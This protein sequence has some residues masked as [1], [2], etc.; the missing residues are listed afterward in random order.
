MISDRLKRT[1]LAALKLPEM[2]IRDETLASEVPGWDSIAHVSV[3]AAVEKEFG[4]RFGGLEVM[5]LKNIG[6]LQKLVSK[7]TR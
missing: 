5:R 1:I 4:I 3:L 2:E 6:E 7:K